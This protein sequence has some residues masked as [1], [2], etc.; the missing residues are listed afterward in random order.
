M[1]VSFL[2]EICLAFVCLP[3]HLSVR[4]GIFAIDHLDPV[5][6]TS[7]LLY[8]DVLIQARFKYWNS[9]LI[10]AGVNSNAK[11]STGMIAVYFDANEN[12]L[13]LVPGNDS[14]QYSLSRHAYDRLEKE[15]L[16]P[17]GDDRDGSIRDAQKKRASTIS[18]TRS[19][20][21]SIGFGQSSSIV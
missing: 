9:Q 12:K 16:A 18:R 3:R 19:N 1:W 14:L 4:A 7:M 5:C 17:L 20:T 11:S 10:D 2:S 6:D 15:A 13:R 21:G 8:N